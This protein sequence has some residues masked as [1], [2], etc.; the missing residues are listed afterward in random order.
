MSRS[1]IKHGTDVSEF[2]GNDFTSDGPASISMIDSEISTP[3]PV[4]S[5]SSNQSIWSSIRSL[6]YNRNPSTPDIPVPLRSNNAMRRD[7]RAES[8]NMHS[9]KTD[10]NRSIFQL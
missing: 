7:D 5:L 4:S 6:L 9:T 2:N 10:S 1:N 8:R 3:A